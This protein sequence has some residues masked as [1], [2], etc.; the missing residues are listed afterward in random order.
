MSAYL[1][2]AEDVTIQ[3]EGVTIAP[4]SCALAVAA[5]SP[6]DASTQ[7]PSSLFAHSL[8]VGF[9]M[10]VCR[11]EDMRCSNESSPRLRPCDRPAAAPC[12]ALPL[13]ERATVVRPGSSG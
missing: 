11:K 9:N 12:Y 4:F 13:D 6:V 8:D 7:A 3:G 2:Q 1:L 5:N 10:L